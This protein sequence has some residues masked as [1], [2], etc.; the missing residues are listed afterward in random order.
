M[1]WALDSPSPPRYPT[2]QFDHVEG[3]EGGTSVQNFFCTVPNNFLSRTYFHQQ[4]ISSSIASSSA[5]SPFIPSVIRQTA[6]KEDYVLFKLDIDSGHVEKG[7]VDHLLSPD[8][9]DLEYIDEFFWEQHVDNYI[10]N[11]PWGDTIDK[12]MTIEDSYHYFLRL[13]Q[14]GVRAHSWV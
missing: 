10:M 12:S 3:W 13:R 9:D 14:Q 11:R 5:Q 2:P 4:W 8:N 7:T 1:A 6:S